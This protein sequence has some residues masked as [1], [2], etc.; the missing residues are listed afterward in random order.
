[1]SLW[2]IRNWVNNSELRGPIWGAELGD[3]GGVDS[4]LCLK[5]QGLGAQASDLDILLRAV[6]RRVIVA[7][8]D[9]VIREGSTAGQVRILL[10]GTACSYKRQENGGR[11]I[12]SFL[13]PGDFCD[14]HRYVLP[15]LETAVGI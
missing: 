8:H 9:D 1:M 5:L 14:L 2:T 15:G 10:A 6:K 3:D 7:A 13:H 12:L 11:S 4:S